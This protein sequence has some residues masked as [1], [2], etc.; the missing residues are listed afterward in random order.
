MLRRL[1]DKLDEITNKLAAFRDLDSLQ[2]R[3]HGGKHRDEIIHLYNELFVALRYFLEVLNFDF[4][5]LRIEIIE[6]PDRNDLIDNGNCYTSDRVELFVV[7]EHVE[8]E[9]QR[10]NRRT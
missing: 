3:M 1:L 10:L 8:S 7:D 6:E 5:Q 9:L 2:S 4:S